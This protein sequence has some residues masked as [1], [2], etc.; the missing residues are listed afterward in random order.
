M[1]IVADDRK[2]PLGINIGEMGFPEGI[3]DGRDYELKERK[4][5]NAERRIM[6][7][8]RYWVTDTEEFN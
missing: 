1:R 6:A 7:D 8:E 5:M 4:R 3:Q 2:W